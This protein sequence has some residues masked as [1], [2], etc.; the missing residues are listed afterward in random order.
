[1][2]CLL[3]LISR[4]T[5][6]TTLDMKIKITVFVC[7]IIL[8]LSSCETKESKINSAKE[9]VMTF[10]NNLLFDNYDTMYDL[11]P[12]FKNVKT[13]WKLN[14]FHITNA[15]LNN[16]LIT[17]IGKSYDTELF[18][19]IEKLNGKYIIIKSKGLS[20]DFGSNLY[21]YCKRIGCIRS[22]SYDE[23]ISKICIE[24]R[25]QFNEL[26]RSIKEKI[27]N[28]FG[29]LNHNVTKSSYGSVSGEITVK[30]NSRFTIPKYSY[31]LYINYCD[32]KGDILF[33]SEETLNY[34]SIPS[35]QN[36]TIHVFELNG[37]SFQKIGVSLKII[38]A[39]FIEEIIAEYAE[40][41]NCIYSDNL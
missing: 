19:E 32:N 23:E 34:E 38:N 3:C 6:K 39:V 14:D 35:G 5:T 16:N 9:V 36:K 15:T 37:N 11:Y 28:N 4:I 20:S 1:M 21:K 30:N 25:Y 29:M 31:H 12:S 27:E 24:K 41:N 17:V 8:I 33:T 2:S 40:G 13:Y 22:N 10:M 26:I 18:F 7:G